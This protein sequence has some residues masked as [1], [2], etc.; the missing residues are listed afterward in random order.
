NDDSSVAS[1]SLLP[2]SS[3]PPVSTVLT[4]SHQTSSKHSKVSAA[5][6][7]RETKML[8]AVTLVGIQ[9]SI[10]HLAEMVKTSFLDPNLVVWEAT[11]MLYADKEV[12]PEHQQFLL[13]LFT[14]NTLIA[15]IYMSIPDTA[16]CHSYIR[17]LYDGTAPPAELVAG[18]SSMNI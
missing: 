10:I 5:S 2:S 12:S 14:K 17:D 3:H 4:T 6:S 13:G 11:A 8:S 16:S 7:V 15:V 9:G 1:P 18:P